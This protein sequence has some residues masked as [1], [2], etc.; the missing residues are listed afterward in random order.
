MSKSQT[1]TKFREGDKLAPIHPG[2][3]LRSEFIEPLALS[4]TKLA[5]LMGV[6]ATRVTAVLSDKQRR[7]ITADTA[8][9]LSC[10]F[11]TSR[12]FWLNLQDCHTL[13][14]VILGKMR[15]KLKCRRYVPRWHTSP[16]FK[17]EI[18]GGRQERQHACVLRLSR[19]CQLLVLSQRRALLTLSGG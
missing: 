8:L 19:L 9:R 11:Q 17:H 13:K 1:I 4:A 6:P 12:E 7:I 16:H 15:H 18:S 3:I 14:I 5:T 2:E 10:A